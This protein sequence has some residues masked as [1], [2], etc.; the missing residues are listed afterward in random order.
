MFLQCLSVGELN[1]ISPLTIDSELLNEA[2]ALQDS[3][4]DLDSEINQAL[5]TA[6]LN[7]RFLNE[8]EVEN[9]L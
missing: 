4:Y 8:T 3:G 9:L 6:M 5:Q 7:S 2:Q 1:L